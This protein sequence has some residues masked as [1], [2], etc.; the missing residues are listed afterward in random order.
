MLFKEVPGQ[1]FFS[2]VSFLYF[3]GTSCYGRALLSIR[4]SCCKTSE[5]HIELKLRKAL[6]M[7]DSNND[8]HDQCE[9][10]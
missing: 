5:A 10:W 9:V 6:Q 8:I 3:D 1:E 4:F 2:K 7:L